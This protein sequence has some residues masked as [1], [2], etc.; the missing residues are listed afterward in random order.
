MHRRR[1]LA[2]IDAVDLGHAAKGIVPI[3]MVHCRLRVFDQMH[4]RI[5]VIA[6][7]VVRAVII[8][9][10]N[11]QALHVF[12]IHAIANPLVA[13]MVKPDVFNFVALVARNFKSIARLD[14]VRVDIVD[15]EIPENVVA[16][17]FVLA[18]VERSAAQVRPAP[19]A[20][21]ALVSADGNPLI[22]LFHRA[23]RDDFQVTVIQVGAGIG[24]K[25]NA[26]ERIV[27]VDIACGTF[28]STPGTARSIRFGSRIA[29][30]PEIVRS[31]GH[32]DCHRIVTLQVLADA[33]RIARHHNVACVAAG[34]GGAETFRL[35]VERKEQNRHR[36]G[37][38]RGPNP[39]GLRVRGKAVQ[40]CPARELIARIVQ[41][42]SATPLR[43]VASLVFP[44]SIPHRGLG[45]PAAAGI[46]RL[47]QVVNLHHHAGSARAV[48]A[49]DRDGIFARQ[50]CHRHEAHTTRLVIF[51]KQGSVVVEP[52]AA[53]GNNP[54]TRTL[55]RV[56]GRGHQLRTDFVTAAI[57]GIR[58]K[59]NDFCS[60]N[61]RVNRRNP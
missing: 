59:R 47:V 4:I 50:E 60:G 37:F 52:V 20:N 28:A 6:V 18:V 43:K 15:G 32:K 35:H 9:V 57:S 24:R 19:H 46:V 22:P 40:G 61:C 45:F 58:R 1:H 26:V 2:S 41:S 3:H 8:H 30:L 12:Q 5:V 33:R 14:Q 16:R 54:N 51:G 39:L 36:V 10:R 55:S 38:R 34:R 13:D 56:V 17:I 7:L 25:V 31:L 42:G 49:D 11:R 29:K 21:Q 53:I 23:H 48:H 27:L 44:G